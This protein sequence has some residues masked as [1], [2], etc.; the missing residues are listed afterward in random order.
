M[1]QLIQCD[2]C[3]DTGFSLDTSSPCQACCPHD[4]QDHFICEDCSKEL[5]PGVYI[6]AAEYSYGDR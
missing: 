4:E 6:D 2:E 1:K 3:Q 5:D